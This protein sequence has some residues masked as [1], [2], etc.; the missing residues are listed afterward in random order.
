MFEMTKLTLADLKTQ[1]S[2]YRNRYPKLPDDD[3]FVLWFLHAYLT[4]DEKKATEAISGGARDK[5]IDAIL[6]DDAAEAVFVVQGKYRQKLNGKLEPR[7]EVMSFAQLA[8]SIG[9]GDNK[10]FSKFLDNTDTY[11]A[12]LLKQARKRVLNRNYRLWLYYA[13]LGKCSKG[14]QEDAKNVVRA[15]NCDAEIQILEGSRLMLL[16]RDYLD[17]VAPPIPVLDLELEKTHGVSINGILQ[18][19]DNANKIESWVFSMRGTSIADLFERS[20]V[21]LFA[22]NIRG[23]LG[24]TTSV[25]RGMATTLTNEPDHFFYYNNGVTIICDKAEK[26]SSQGRDILR[27]SNPQIINGQQTTRM[28]ATYAGKTTIPSVLIKV[29]QVPRN[30]S[31]LK[32]DYDVLVNKIV[33]GTNWQ[34]AIRPSDLRSND[35][36]QIELERELRKIGYTY[37]RKRQTKGEVKAIFG[38]KSRFIVK[39][40][41]LAQAVAGCGMDPVVVRSGREKLFEDDLYTKVFPTADPN[42][43]LSRYWLMR[44]VTFCARKY[45]QRGYAKWVVL[46]FVWSSLSPEIRKKTNLR[47]FRR[48]CERKD[49]DLLGPLYD[50]INRVYV[51]VLKYYNQNK[52]SGEK[53]IDISQFFRSR[54][55]RDKDFLK[56]WESSDNGSR[57]FFEKHW[58]KTV[59]AILKYEN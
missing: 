20:G 51:A 52:G 38:G 17:G 2:G 19:F 24:A 16:L 6:I 34:N 29:I 28:L 12:T 18:R 10:L 58:R 26:R 54:K 42:Y 32:G 59:N 57:K 13:T 39:K 7:T 1:I 56:F 46:N 14:L 8:N 45:P 44:G 31:R 23:F 33:A 25:N 49:E 30:P 53:Q 47:A 48:L 55:G 5:G 15:A 22:R 40:E 21:R 36:L 27:V 41:E 3:L 11:V 35:R 37:V 9:E 43:Y 50:A 4:D